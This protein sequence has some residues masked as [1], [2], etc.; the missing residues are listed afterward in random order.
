MKE[1]YY[2][3]EYNLIN[4]TSAKQQL[5][6]KA[7]ATSGPIRPEDTIQTQYKPFTQHTAV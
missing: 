2:P 3:V 1:K 5:I 4:L 7:C 6:A